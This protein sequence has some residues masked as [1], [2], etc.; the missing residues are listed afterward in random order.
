[1]KK[2]FALLV[3][4]LFLTSCAPK[5]QVAILQ[6]ADLKTDNSAFVYENDT[7]LLKYNFYSNGGIVRFSVFNKLNVPIYIDWKKTAFIVGKQKMDYW[8]NEATTYGQMSRYYYGGWYGTITKNERIT[9]IPPG[10]EIEKRSYILMSNSK[11]NDLA[12]VAPQ[13]IT[14]SWKANKITRIKHKTYTPEDTPLAFRNYITYSTNQDFTKE[15]Y[16]DNYFWVKEIMEMSDK[17]FMGKTIGITKSHQ[18]IFQLPYKA[19][20]AFYIQRMP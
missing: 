19:P 7:L 4:L 17:Q 3:S 9:F 13:E 11:F 2:C 16:I 20:D 8:T 1:M 18:Y 14:A 5:V 12:H 6:S 15:A 10:T